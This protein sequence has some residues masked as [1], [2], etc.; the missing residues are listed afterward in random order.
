M[1]LEFWP[2]VSSAGGAEAGR[3]ASRDGSP[4]DQGQ[5]SAPPAWHGQPL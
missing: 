2:A 1:L 3:T 5:E 4:E